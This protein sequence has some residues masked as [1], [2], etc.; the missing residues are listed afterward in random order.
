M[1]AITWINTD[2]ADGSP[3]TQLDDAVRSIASNAAR[4][5]GES[6][7]W[8]GAGGGS[9][10]SA[11]FSKAGAARLLRDTSLSDTTAVDGALGLATTLGAAWHLGTGWR[12]VLGHAS[13]LDRDG[14]VSGTSLFWQTESGSTTTTGAV[15]EVTFASEF[16]ATPHIGMTVSDKRFLSGLSTR[17]VSGFT[18]IASWLDAGSASMYT[19]TWIAEGYRAT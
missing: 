12:H 14:I 3:S 6:L 2:P 11:G 17:G 4:G 10:T 19:L 8:P 18:S 7:T 13:L 9:T 15:V 5:L 16:S 1:S